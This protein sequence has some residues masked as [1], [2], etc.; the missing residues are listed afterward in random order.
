MPCN[1][2]L[3]RMTHTL[4]SRGTLRFSLLPSKQSREPLFALSR[5]TPTEL[6]LKSKTMEPKQENED[7]ST[8]SVQRELSADT[9]SATATTDDE[10]IAAEEW[11]ALLITLIRHIL[12]NGVGDLVKG[13]IRQTLSNLGGELVDILHL[14]EEARE[15]QER[16]RLHTYLLEKGTAELAAIVSRLP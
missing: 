3:P 15:R 6:D 14:L 13:R 8:N 7:R 10:P 5:A 11:L 2:R 16:L 12:A 4:C 9:S 1:T